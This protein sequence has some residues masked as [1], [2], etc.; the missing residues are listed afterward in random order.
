[1][2]RGESVPGAMMHKP[3]PGRTARG[4]RIDA[5]AREV[6]IHLRGELSPPLRED[7]LKVPDTPAANGDPIEQREMRE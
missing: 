1:M 6:A 4:K 3:C 2:A 5:A 7:V